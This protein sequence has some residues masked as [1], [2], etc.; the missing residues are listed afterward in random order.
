MPLKIARTLAAGA[1]AVVPGAEVKQ[2]LG[3]ATKGAPSADVMDL[4][5]ATAKYGAALK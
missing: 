5:E 4:I 1:V 3:L 2:A